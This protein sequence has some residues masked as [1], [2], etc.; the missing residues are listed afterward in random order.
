MRKKYSTS[1]AWLFELCALLFG[2]AKEVWKQ[3]RSQVTNYFIS[4][5]S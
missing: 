1:G 2:I 3:A 4:L 5:R